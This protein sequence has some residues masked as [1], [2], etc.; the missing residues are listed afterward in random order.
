MD[1]LAHS[2]KMGKN[3]PRIFLAGSPGGGK[4]SLINQLPKYMGKTPE[5]CPV[6]TLQAT[7]YAPDEIKGLPT[8][9]TKP[10][11]DQIAVFLPFDDIPNNR[12]EGGIL[13]IDDLPHAPT[14]TQNALMRLVLE[15]VC[16]SR[17]LGSIIPFATGNRAKDK[18]GAKDM[19]TAL[20]N[21]FTMIEL[22]INYDD[23]RAWAIGANLRP[24]I[25][26]FLGS[27]YGSKWISDDTFS[28]NR[29]INPTPR[30]WE[31]AS[32]WYQTFNGSGHP[33]RECLNGCVGGEATTQFLAYVKVFSKLPDLDKIAAGEKIYP[34][35]LDIFYAAVG[36]LSQVAK[37]AKNKPVVFNNLINYVIGIPDKFTEMGVVLSKDLYLMDKEVFSKCN[38]INAWQKK[39]EAIVL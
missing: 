3:G 17:E 4:T 21:R 33:M 13:C 9:L 2:Y 15:G 39:F 14:A 12:Q 38:N 36:G 7:L 19:Q 22:E 30:S 5:E 6:Y 32:K 24:E 20:A 18:A 10:N 23:W 37:N 29:Q 35:T 31:A 16:G 27:P 11:G 28:P 8:L 25:I 1:V 34:D 26:S